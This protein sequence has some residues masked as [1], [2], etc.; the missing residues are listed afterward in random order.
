S[1]DE[2]RIQL[3]KAQEEV[4]HLKN[5]AAEH[6]AAAAK[7]QKELHKL[8]TAQADVASVLLKGR[9]A[10]STDLVA[11]LQSRC[12]ELAEELIA[13]QADASHLR[14]QVNGIKLLTH[15]RDQALRQA[16]QV[17]DEAMLLEEHHGRERMTWVLKE[18]TLYG[19]VE[20]AQVELH[21][22]ESELA[23]IK[24]LIWDEASNAG[25]SRG[26]ES[27]D[28]VDVGRWAKWMIS[29]FDKQ[30]RQ[31]EDAHAVLDMQH[32][33]L[34]SALARSS[35]SG[36][37]ETPPAAYAGHLAPSAGRSRTSSVGGPLRP[38]PS[39]IQP[40]AQARAAAWTTQVALSLAGP[41]A[42]AAPPL[43]AAAAPAERR[44]GE[45]LA[46]TLARLTARY[47]RLQQELASLSAQLDHQVMANAEIKRLIVDGAVAGGGSDAASVLERYNDALVEVGALRTEVDRLRQRCEELERGDVVQAATAGG[48]AAAVAAAD[49][50]AAYGGGC[51]I[52]GGSSAINAGLYFQPPASDWDNFHPDGWKSSDVAA[53]TKSLYERQPSVEVTNPSNVQ[54]GYEAA[55]K[56][57]V[58]GAGYSEVVFND[59]P[60][61][62]NAVFGHTSYDYASGQRGGPVTTYLQSA[63]QRPNFSLQSNV[64]VSREVRSGSN[65][66]GVSAM[67]DGVE[68]TINLSST[69]RVV[70]SAGAI[71]SPAAIRNRTGGPGALDPALSPSS[72]VNNSDVGA[73]LFDNPNTFIELTAPTVDSYTYSYESPIEADRDMYLNDR[74]GPY[75]YA[76]QT[77][78]FWTY[79]NHTDGTAPTGLQGTIGTAGYSD[80]TNDS[81]I[82]LNIYG[83][84]GLLSTGKVALTQ[85]AKTGKFKP[86]GGNGNF[87]SDSAGR[88]ADAIAQ[89]IADLFAALDKSG[90]G[91]STS[92]RGPP[93]KR[94]RGS[95]IQITFANS[96]GRISAASPW[97]KKSSDPSPA[98]APLSGLMT[99]TTAPFLLAFSV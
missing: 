98:Q 76:G 10:A 77:S 12:E 34:E 36:E 4:S 30:R 27:A 29:A 55:R 50:S 35:V 97:K 24:R 14:E 41:G 60:D 82:T 6:E 59:V 63:L 73:G 51:T 45:P 46:A 66:T 81:S 18:R 15:E 28:D 79:I 87:Y 86:G 99:A 7:F 42:P 84:S 56:W 47:A 17:R 37:S 19:E 69:G 8:R 62:K 80:Y 96:L 3:S 20:R 1:V 91:R 26:T 70:L 44:G 93:R 38:R 53:A 95:N 32:E 64:T 52:G 21:R 54:S 61:Q 58:D 16:T 90:S 40:S 43:A 85:D 25:W 5:V 65:A 89:F 83:S 9:Q 72:S 31:L 13:S 23:G 68:T 48:G 22:F 71:F 39:G 33:R 57:L 49:R 88:D 11:T 78:A 75:S 92:P 2:L 74:S 94:S 67:V